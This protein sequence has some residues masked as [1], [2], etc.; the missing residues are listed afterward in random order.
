MLTQ[1]K[2]GSD[3]VT[4]TDTSYPVATITNNSSYEVVIYDV[5]NPS[6]GATTV[7]YEYT[8]LETIAVG[9]T[10]EVQT[11]RDVSMLQAMYTGTIEQI[12]DFYC[13]QFPIKVMSVMQFSFGD[14]PPITYSIEKT[15]EDAMIQ[16][17]LFHR[18]AMANP[19]SSLTKNLYASLK[20]GSVDSVNDFFA[21]TKNF[22]S[23]TLSSWNAIQSWLQM[24][25]SGWQGPY[26]LY[27][28]EPDPAPSDYVP[29]LI[30]TL[31]ITSTA[32]DNTAT[33]K[34]CSEDSKG[35]PVY[36]DPPETTTIIMNGDGTMG[37]SNP[38][39][40]VSVSLTPVWMNV[41]QTTMKDGVPTSNYIVG[42]VVTGTIANKKVV[43]TQV[44]RQLP[45]KKSSGSAQQESS[46]DASFGKICQGVGLLVGLL[47]LGDFAA[48]IGKSAKNKLTKS[49]EKAESK[50]EF[51]A[52]EKTINETP[53]AKV[54]SEATEQEATFSSDA[55][56]V[57]DSYADTSEAL[58]EDVMMQTMEDTS[59]SISN[60]IR[61]QVEDGYTPTEDFES[62]VQ[63][64]E[65]SFSDAKAKIESGDFSE[66]SA[67]L[68]TASKNIDIT[69]QDS[70]AEMHDW[71]SQ[72]LQESSDA[73]KDAAS[74]SEA[75]DEAQDA[76]EKTLENE[77]D[78]S[79]FDAEDEKWPETDTIPEEL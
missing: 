76:R 3:A 21:G 63:D 15:D 8:K 37:D 32:T 42:P 14:P 53:D 66:A 2:S 43:S 59:S 1:S 10:K 71:E 17:F 11:I 18:F 79:G 52:Q 40:D 46:F 67:E 48:K 13:Y 38:G 16:S 60:E 62:A 78:D 12:N 29:V 36:A 61:E 30:A 50:E 19:D 44:A 49:K 47:M 22:T 4:A 77:A 45:S 24:F 74:A 69:L 41:I 68:S 70:S 6:K 33:L 25:T 65:T 35:N 58:Q 5:Y 72:S 20:E 56:K 34:M 75:L 31:D 23:C 51:E 26:F 54:V 64:L 7:P 9:A 28:E 73:V 55:S 27:E 57:S 39:Q